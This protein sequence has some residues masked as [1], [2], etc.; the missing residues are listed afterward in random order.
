MN[1]TPPSPP[2]RAELAAKLTRELTSLRDALV[3][4]SLSLKD[5]QYELD[6]NGR[7]LSQKAA[8]DALDKFRLHA[9]PGKHPAA[10]SQRPAAGNT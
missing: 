5:W 4:L 8:F 3:S 1:T 10:N 9:A 6:Q 2:N 7:K